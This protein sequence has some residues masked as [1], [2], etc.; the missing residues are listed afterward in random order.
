MKKYPNL[1]VY[2]DGDGGGWQAEYFNFTE[3]AEELLVK[4][5][6][7]VDDD[8]VVGMWIVGKDHCCFFAQG[9]RESGVVTR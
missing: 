2:M 6:V 7:N 3:S 4:V 9:R 5:L 1:D 8:R